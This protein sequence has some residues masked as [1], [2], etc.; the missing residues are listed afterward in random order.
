MR[1]TTTAA[2]DPV[3]G[4][5]RKRQT[6]GDGDTHTE[7]RRA[8]GDTG[9]NRRDTAGSQRV[10]GVSTDMADGPSRRL[11]RPRPDFGLPGFRAAGG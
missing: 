4:V 11:G 5:L 10:T 9:R 8:C 6:S 3:T 2:L 7:G 1:A